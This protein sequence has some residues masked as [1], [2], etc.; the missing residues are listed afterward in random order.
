MTVFVKD[1]KIWNGG[2]WIS[3]SLQTHNYSIMWFEDEKQFVLLVR[4]LR[5]VLSLPSETQNSEYKLQKTELISHWH[6]IRQFHVPV[7]LM[8]TTT[9]NLTWTWQG[10]EQ[11]S[12]HWSVITGHDL[13]PSLTVFTISLCW[14]MSRWLMVPTNNIVWYTPVSE[15]DLT[16]IY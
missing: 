2:G 12:L 11:Y 15:S 4:L 14:S 10:L 16:R 8:V 5:T 7:T 13:D 1:A 6:H 3:V 9:Y